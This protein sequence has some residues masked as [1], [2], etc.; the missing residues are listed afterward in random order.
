MAAIEKEED[1]FRVLCCDPSVARLFSELYLPKNVVLLPNTE[2]VFSRP[3]DII[4]AL[5]K[6]SKAKKEMLP[7]LLN[8][9]PAKILFFFVGFN[10]FE[11]WLIKKMAHSSQV[12]YRYGV[13]FST[14]KPSFN[15]KMWLKALFY[16]A[17]YLIPFTAKKIGEYH[18]NCIS[19]FF[20]K[21]IKA[22]SYPY[23]S[24]M[25][26]AEELMRR[27]YPEIPELKVLLLIGG[28]QD[29]DVE[30]Y[31]KEMSAILSLLASSLEP[32]KIGVKA[33][34]NFDTPD[35]DMPAGCIM[36]PKYTSATLLFFKCQ[37]VISYFSGTLH[38]AANAGKKAISLLEIIHALNK[39]QS[40]GYKKYILSNTKKEICFP[41]TVDEL[42]KIIKGELTYSTSGE[43][44]DVS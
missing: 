32:Q 11:S 3:F 22:K 33:H 18:L 15:V 38:Q 13:N 31:K 43:G 7:I 27:K 8:L 20:L 4:K 36:L 12:F 17:I 1:D 29:I 19:T 25:K 40:E 5:I 44:G 21:M 9:R 10:G 28:E 30:I 35:I 6:I 34:P 41:E 39:K 23:L 24:G 37:I 2:I 16:S 42:L 14:F 26:Y